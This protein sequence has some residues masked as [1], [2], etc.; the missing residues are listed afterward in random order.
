MNE[1]EY[2]P[3]YDSVAHQFAEDDM[4]VL[5]RASTPAQ[6]IVQGFLAF[7]DGSILVCDAGGIRFLTGPDAMVTDTSAGTGWPQS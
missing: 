5:D 6:R 1:D 7:D 2:T 3:T 4:I